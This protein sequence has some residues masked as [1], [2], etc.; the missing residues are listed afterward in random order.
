MGDSSDS[1]WQGPLAG[2]VA[3]T[4]ALLALAGSFKTYSETLG[5]KIVAIIVFTVS[6]AWA[7][8]YL[9]AKT[10]EAPGLVGAEPRRVPLH[11]HKLRFLVLLLPLLVLITG[12][13]AVV[14][15]REPDYS[16]LLEGGGPYSPILILDSVPRGAEVRLAWVIRAEADPSLENKGEDKELR[17]KI[18]R[19]RTL[20]RVRV[21][22][23]PYWVV[24]RLNGRTISKR[25]DVIGP[26]VVRA[27]FARGTITVSH[28][29]S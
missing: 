8:W 6:A 10:T 19:G 2:P 11:R 12:L 3:A 22:Q 15:S 14:Q 24:F 27:N 20:C 4:A 13:A 17:E 7:G 21:D 28:R 26:T 5:W 9:A 1:R 18:F 16:A 23:L 25:V 29:E